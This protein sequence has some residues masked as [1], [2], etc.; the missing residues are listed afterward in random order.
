M[1]QVQSNSLIIKCASKSKL[2]TFM[3]FNNF[4]SIPDCI[5][6]PLYKAEQS[7][8]IPD[9][10]RFCQACVAKRKSDQEPVNEHVETE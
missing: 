9:E 1:L 7:P 2:R 10:Q 3:L 6:K 8:R 4:E 5:L